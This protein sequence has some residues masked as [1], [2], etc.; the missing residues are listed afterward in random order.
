ME[1]CTYFAAGC[2]EEFCAAVDRLSLDWIANSG[3]EIA[4]GQYEFSTN[5][6][7]LYDKMR[8]LTF[9][10]KRFNDKSVFWEIYHCESCEASSA[11]YM[12][13]SRIST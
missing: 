9:A 3:E 7:R 5:E 12:L 6:D 13:H 10:S 1:S 4:P 2:Y 8:Y 11:Q